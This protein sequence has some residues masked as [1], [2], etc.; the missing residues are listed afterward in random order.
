SIYCG[1]TL[2]KEFTATKEGKHTFKVNDDYT[3]SVIEPDDPVE[4]KTL[5]YY[6]SLGW[7]EVYCHAWIDGGEDITTWPGVKLTEVEGKENWYTVTLSNTSLTG[8]RVIFNNNAGVQS[9]TI[10]DFSNI[11]FFGQSTTSYASYE[12]AESAASVVVVYDWYLRGSMNSWIGSEAYGL[13]K[14]GNEYV[15]TITLNAGDTLK[16]ADDANA[17]NNNYGY[18]N[19]ENKDC[20]EQDSDNI[21][22]KTTGEY[23]F[24]IKPSSNSIWIKAPAA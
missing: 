8:L 6:N 16:F 3:V 18:Y 21:K 19:V 9:G 1:T 23:T 4:E 13:T 20:I 12:E 5:Y 22:I 24:Y 14:S 7:S 2:L 15:I 17:W 10:S 11:Y